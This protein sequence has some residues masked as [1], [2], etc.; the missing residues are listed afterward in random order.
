MHTAG[1]DVR[2]LPSPLLVEA[3]HE[4]PAAHPHVNATA[5]FAAAFLLGVASAV[6][7]LVR[8]VERPRRAVTPVDD[9]GR[10]SGVGKLSLRA[11]VLATSL[12]SVGLVGYV[13]VRVGSLSAWHAALW[14]VVIAAV[15]SPVAARVVRRW[16]FRAAT[17][18][19]PDPRY[20]L[21]GHIAQVIEPAT[22]HQLARVE[23]TSNGRR[24]VAA[25]CSLDHA[26]LVP[27]TEVVIDRLEDAVVY[28][29]A[30]AQVEQRL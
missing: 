14:G 13:L 12:L 5:G 23:Y 20:A 4:R 25:A 15:A 21:Q 29:E 6:Y 2:Q 3:V 18:D 7:V 9:F 28:V 11:P 30:W 24:V 19:A 8:G 17:D 22:E 10:E 27:G 26:P 16:A 1:G